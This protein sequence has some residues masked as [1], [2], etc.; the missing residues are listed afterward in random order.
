[1]R[2]L[3]SVDVDTRN[4]IET[5]QSR[6]QK[7]SYSLTFTE[8]RKYVRVVVIKYRSEKGN[9]TAVVKIG[10]VRKAGTTWEASYNK[11]KQRWHHF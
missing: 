1:M 10:W 2:G 5:E 3:E 7:V 8:N 6:D 11:A 9:S 4:R